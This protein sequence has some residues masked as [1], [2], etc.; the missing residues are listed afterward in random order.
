MKEFTWKPDW[1]MKRSNKPNVNV[2][3]FG[4]GYQQRQKGGINH[5]LKTYDVVFTGSEERINAIDDFLNEHGGYQAFLWSPYLET[6]RKF[7][8]AEWDT[9]EQTGFFTLTATFNEVVA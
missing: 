4:D 8:C 3:E 6:Q 5:N 1:N 9:N 7:T 2:V